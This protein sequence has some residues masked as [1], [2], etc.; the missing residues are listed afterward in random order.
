[1]L[2]MDKFSTDELKMFS[3][4]LEKCLHDPACQVPLTV[5]AQRFSDAVEAGV[6]QPHTLEAI[7]LG[8]GT[9]PGGLGLPPSMRGS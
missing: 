6:T 2:N 8:A 5:M 4:I 7:I 3:N 1:M 9:S